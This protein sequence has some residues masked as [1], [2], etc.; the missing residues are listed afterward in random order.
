MKRYQVLETTTGQ[1]VQ[2]FDD[3]RRAESL[4]AALTDEF[5]SQGLKYKVKAVAPFGMVSLL[6]NR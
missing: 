1:T 4:A 2:V 6:G 5:K 3:K